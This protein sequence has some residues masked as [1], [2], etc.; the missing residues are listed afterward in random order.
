ML[1]IIGSSF[2]TSYM[3]P[4]V[5]HY[6]SFLEGENLTQ[7]LSYIGSRGTSVRNQIS[8]SVPQV[9]FAMTT[10]NGQPLT[11][12]TSF[13]T[14][15]GTGWV[16]VRDIR[17]A[18]TN[19]PLE[20]TWTSDRTWRVSVP[21]A[22]GTQTVTLEAIGFD[23]SVMGTT[24]ITVTKTGSTAWAALRINEFMAFQSNVPGSRG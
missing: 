17:I 22:T 23:G 21:V 9:N 18:G 4:W 1:D 7:W 2:N 15:Q 10:N 24:S 11:V 12:D 14:L 20:V 13:V 3:S 8:A 19:Q 6:T 5:A 16:N